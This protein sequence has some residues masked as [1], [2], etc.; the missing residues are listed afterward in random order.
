[1]RGIAVMGLEDAQDLTQAFFVR[2]LARDF[3]PRPIQN[4]DDSARF[5]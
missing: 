5:S 1:M 2:V 3:L 4:V